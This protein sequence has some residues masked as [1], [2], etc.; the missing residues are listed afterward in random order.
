[1]KDEDQALQFQS[2][3]YIHPT[4]RM[5]VYTFS[6]VK[7]FFF[8]FFIYKHRLLYFQLCESK[9]GLHPGV[10]SL[11]TSLVRIYRSGRQNLRV[12]LHYFLLFLFSSDF[13]NKDPK[14]FEC[15]FYLLLVTGYECIVRITH[16]PV[17]ADSSQCSQFMHKLS[18]SYT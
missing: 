8:F 3:I 2:T 11:S 14:F 15:G 18:C 7:H 10:V 13:L 5:V 9:G 6:L 1:V 12:I 17:L 16:L 4:S